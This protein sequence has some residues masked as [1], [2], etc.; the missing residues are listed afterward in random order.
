MAT[1]SSQK[2]D[3]RP[4]SFLLRN[5]HTGQSVSVP[6]VIRPEDLTRPEPGLLMPA[7]TFAG[8]FIDD[9]GP[10]LS[11]IQISGHTGWRGGETEDGAAAF[12]SL[13]EN[14]WVQ[15]HAQRKA[16]VEAG[17]PADSVKLIFSDVL[18][19]ITVVVAPGNFTLRR[20]K[21][22][23]LLMMYSIPMT[24]LGDQIDTPTADPLDFNLGDPSANSV[25][26]GAGSLRDSLSKIQAAA[27]KVHAMVESSLVAPVKG[28]L[29][30]AN[31]AFSEVLSVVDTARG[32]VNGESAQLIGLA[33]DIAQ[34]GRNA[35]YT[36]NAV[37]G[38]P[39]FISHDVAAVGSSFENAFCVLRNSLRL[40]RD[41][42]DY[43]DIYGSASCSSTVGGSPLSPL[44][45]V[46]G[47]EAILPTVG[48]RISVSPPARS[49]I[50][51]M[52]AA[53]PVLRPMGASDLAARLS[54]IAGGVAFQ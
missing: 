15:W 35:F 46:N 5:E 43:D 23:P 24:V 37:A 40:A 25:I 13:R 1:P 9:F 6:L 44:G 12:K 30:T 20:N 27:D 17:Q 28:F 19:D 31:S 3:Q 32:I 48:L 29:S 4:I 50:E 22:R 11:S 53:D 51:V 16:A 39:D 34:A 33:G 8:A 52:K 42:P 2:A 10:G 54:A 26:A 45:G 36:Y 49:A 47:W 7:Q 41:Y 18:D 21:Q 14:V 38:L